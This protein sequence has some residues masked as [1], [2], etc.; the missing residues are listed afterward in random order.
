[1]SAESAPTGNAEL[2]AW[3]AE[4]AALTRPAGVYWCDGSGQEYDRLCAEMVAAGTLI[5]LNPERRPGCYLARSD[6]TDVARVENRTFVCPP[7]QS[8]AG[9]TNNWADP[10][11][12]KRTLRGLFDGAMRGRR[13]YVIPFSMG[14]LGS[15]IAH[16]GVQLTDSPY[17]A[18]SM[19]VMTRMGQPALD[20]LGDGDFVP[21]MHTLGAPLGP[22][23]RDV[24]WPC[25]ETKYI[26]HFP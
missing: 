7:D 25:N 6:P 4:M 22:G 16:I 14:P 18:A 21:C 12:M 10:Q 1:M 11:E 26:V 17:V 23:Q 20:F 24:S 2:I 19:R 9:P 3:V 5:K 15:P 13:M 8:D